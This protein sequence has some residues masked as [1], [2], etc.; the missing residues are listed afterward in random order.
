[1]YC[2]R[3]RYF[4]C[5]DIPYSLSVIAL[6]PA[7]R[8]SSRAAPSPHLTRWVIWP[9]ETASGW[10]DVIVQLCKAARHTETTTTK[11]ELLYHSCT[12][13]GENVEGAGVGLVWGG[14]TPQCWGSTVGPCWFVLPE[15]AAVLECQDFMQLPFWFQKVVKT[16]SLCVWTFSP[17]CTGLFR[18]HCTCTVCVPRALTLKLSRGSNIKLARVFRNL[19]NLLFWHLDFDNNTSI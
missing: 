7:A 16:L 14:V 15:G 1:M 9:A 6:F 5:L 19:E 12:L 13:P 2:T 8:A 17:L 3:S 18:Q 10:T 11:R 4:L